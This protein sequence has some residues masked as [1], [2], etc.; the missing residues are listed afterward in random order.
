METITYNLKDR[1]KNSNE[2]YRCISEFTDEVLKKIDITEGDVIDEF[3]KFLR[4][5]NIEQIRSREEYE[6]EFLIISILRKVYIDRALNTKIIPQY[7]SLVFSDIM[8]RLKHLKNSIGKFKGILSY[9]YIIGNG[10]EVDKI[11]YSND[12]FK[13]LIFWLK[14]SGE[15]KYEVKRMKIWEMFFKNSNESYIFKIN[16]CFVKTANWFKKKSREKLGIYT[17]NIEKYLNNDYKMHLTME[18]NIFCGRTEV[19]YHLNMVGAEILNRA[20]RKL[21]VKTNKKRLFLPSCMCLRK[22]GICK[23]TKAK[24]G[25]LCKACSENCNVN[26]LTKLGKLHNFKVIVIPHETDAFS[27]TKNIKYGDVGIVGIA[28]I[29]N[30]IEG[31]F[32]ARY[33][34]LVPQCVILDYCGCKNHWHKKGIQTDINDEKLFEILQI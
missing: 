34:N 15:F 9:K 10:T 6:L 3:M 23:K 19:E 33:L 12:D 22:N 29:L 28:C 31:G 20:F 2:Y 13:K 7:I 1:Y 25:F 24:D 17:L 27:N 21:F 8:V 16:E 30:L 4:D 32:K 26:K 5:F 11:F 14:S 18:D